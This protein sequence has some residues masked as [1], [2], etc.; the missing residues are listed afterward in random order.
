MSLPV[1]A[2]ALRLQLRPRFERGSLVP[3]PRVEHLLLRPT[4]QREN[5]ARRPRRLALEGIRK[6][7]LA[8]SPRRASSSET[9]GSKNLQWRPWRSI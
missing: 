4:R 6:N 9:L 8:L 2:S 7:L 1:M 5:E 3:V